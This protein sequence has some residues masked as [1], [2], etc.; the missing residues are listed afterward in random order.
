MANRYVNYL[1]QGFKS[2]RVAEFKGQNPET[3]YPFNPSTSGGES[4][5]GARYLLA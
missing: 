1:V 5:G 4:G 3:L 2:L